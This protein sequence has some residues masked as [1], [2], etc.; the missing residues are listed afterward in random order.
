VDTQTDPQNCGSCAV[1]CTTGC[2]QGR[3]TR[4]ATI[5]TGYEHTC[6]VLT[7]GTVSCWGANAFGQLG[8]GTETPLT[9]SPV[10][11]TGLTNAIE[12][13]LGFE[14]S[15]AL[16]RG[17]TAK[18]WGDDTMGQ[19]GNGIHL[20]TGV[21]T[22]VAT[23]TPV[24]GLTTATTITAGSVSDVACAL[25][26]DGTVACWGDDL[27]GAL[28]DGVNGSQGDSSTPV[29]VTGLKGVV[30]I[31]GGGAHTCALLAGGSVECWG[32]QLGTG[33]GV[34]QATAV[35]G[36]S[37][38]GVTALAGGGSHTCALMADGTVECWGDNDHGQLGYATTAICLPGI[39]VPCSLTAA[40]VPS[41]EGVTA[42]AGGGSH[43]CALL[44]DGTVRCWGRNDSGQLGNGTTSDSTTPVTVSN[45]TAVTEIAAGGSHTC[46]RLANGGVRCWGWNLSGQL[47]NGTTT[48]SSVPV[49]VF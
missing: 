47:G 7:D 34:E 44:K 46:A 38:R 14:F 43:T 42:L 26:V 2:V 33:T 29:S 35:P 4:P 6:A 41:L 11:V 24:S 1:T 15:C 27:E 12:I 36:P 3:C 31:A 13:T 25:L 28:G 17:G 32:S 18:C 20:P 10:K 23:P 49:V 39:N 40:A 30:S 45:L 21:N 22:P 16:V 19:V 48:D 5:A 9:A 37:V 8:D